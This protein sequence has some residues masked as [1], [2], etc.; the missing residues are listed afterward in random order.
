MK[1]EKNIPVPPLP[2]RA[3]RPARYPFKTMAVGESF[4]VQACATIPE[5][6][7]SLKCSVSIANK[8]FAPK[9]FEIRRDGIAARIFRTV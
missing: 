6:Y 9:N 1:V 3:G 8:K 5:P 7:N 4:L 2:K